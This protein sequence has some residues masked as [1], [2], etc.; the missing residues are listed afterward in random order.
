MTQ[1]ALFAVEYAMA[2]LWLSWGIK[3]AAMIGHSLGEYV[4][5]CLAEVFSLEDA[6]RAVASRAQWV[7]EQ[8]PGAM[9]AVRLT[10]AELQSYL[11]PEFPSPPSTLPGPACLRLI[12]SDRKR[13]SDG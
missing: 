10:E 6:L 8:P 3:P 4:C 12:L 9:T 2:K 5:G 11:T 1:P 7:Q 13:S